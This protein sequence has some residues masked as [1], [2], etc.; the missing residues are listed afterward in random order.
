MRNLAVQRRKNGIKRVKPAV[1][2]KK[3][4]VKNVITAVFIKIG[5][6]LTKENDEPMAVEKKKKVAFKVCH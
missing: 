1:E 3:D 6:Q 4:Y 2:G 5:F